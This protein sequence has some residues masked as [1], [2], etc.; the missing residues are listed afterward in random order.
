MWAFGARAAALGLLAAGGA[1]ARAPFPA[2]QKVQDLDFPYGPN[3][4]PYVDGVL[5]HSALTAVAC[6]CVLS[7][8]TMCGAFVA[9]LC[10]KRKAP[11]EEEA[12]VM[13]QK[14]ARALD[15]RENIYGVAFVGAAF[16]AVLMIVCGTVAVVATNNVN[17][18][19]ND[20][21]DDTDDFFLA[22]GRSLCSAER[23]DLNAR[24]CDA[25]SLWVYLKLARDNGATSLN[26][27]VLAINMV[28]DLNTGLQ[29][30]SDWLGSVQDDVNDVED[31]LYPNMEADLDRIGYLITWL[32]DSTNTDGQ[33]ITAELPDESDLPVFT[34]DTAAVFT[35]C[36]DYADSVGETKRELD[37]TAVLYSAIAFEA[38]RVTRDQIDLDPTNADTDIRS[39]VLGNI[40]RAAMADIVSANED[41]LDF[42]DKSNDSYEGIDKR[43]RQLLWLI[44]LLFFIPAL[45]QIV[46]ILIA[47]WRKK[48]Y[49]LGANLAFTCCTLQVYLI[50]AFVFAL[51]AIVTNDFCD[52]NLEFIETQAN[53][54][55][56]TFA[57]NEVHVDEVIVDILYCPVVPEAVTSADSFPWATPRNNY[58]G[59]FGLQ[60]TF[61]IAGTVAN[62]T[63]SLQDA[64]NDI[65]MIDYDS[66]RNYG[67]NIPESDPTAGLVLSYGDLSQYAA[68]V[69][70]LATYVEG[71]SATVVANV[72]EL[73]GRVASLS[74]NITELNAT[75]TETTG[76]RSE[77]QYRI[78]LA[79][80]ET[81][82]A[83]SGLQGTIN[84]ILDLTDQVAETDNYALC[85]YVGIFYEVPL[86]KPRQSPQLPPA[87]VS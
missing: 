62:V 7:Y 12:K 38:V 57:E 11:T 18:G 68:E 73:E 84:G 19:F 27:G 2:D 66:I 36:D 55:S 76:A 23:E 4:Q 32:S 25:S 63:D 20:T 41:M 24:R 86:A 30:T 21:H 81:N 80:N 47:C 64:I 29:N 1:M 3:V 79:A 13:Q 59:I 51:L 56:F 22:F 82:L 42:Y 17:G 9:C 69:E 31:E 40:I 49:P 10:C 74:G 85:G 28:E 44:M 35:S 52:S 75:S 39:E 6:I 48:P 46:T 77:Y 14:T 33:D 67:D 83:V 53:G 15:P 8:I 87:H 61:N 70:D 72:A 58:I 16:L 26:G 5:F 54:K 45:I 65:G 34:S 71:F 37:R 78:D 43:Q 60:Q 50:I